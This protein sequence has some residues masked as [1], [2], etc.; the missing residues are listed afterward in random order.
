MFPSSAHTNTHQHT[1]QCSH[2]AKVS[3]KPKGEPKSTLLSPPLLPLPLMRL[4]LLLQRRRW[5][6]FV[7]LV[8][9]K[10]ERN[11]ISSKDKMKDERMAT[12]RKRNYRPIF[13]ILISY[14]FFLLSWTAID[15]T[16]RPTPYFP[17]SHF[18]VWLLLSGVFCTIGWV[19]EWTTNNNNNAIGF[20]F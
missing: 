12:K 8:S 1:E 3:F 13:P 19:L 10:T 20:W 7:C 4:V 16:D 15:T 14:I 9:F 11:R 2:V 18:R 5:S 17:D 6:P